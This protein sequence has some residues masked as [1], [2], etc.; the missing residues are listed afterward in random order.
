MKKE[1][2]LTVNETVYNIVLETVG[3]GSSMPP[4][5]S[6]SAAP[7]PRVS[8]PVSAPTPAPAP[9]STSTAAP[10]GRGE[11]V[12]APMPGNVWKVKVKNGDVVKKGDVLIIL[13][14]M[15]MEN[16]IMAMCDGTVSDFSVSEGQSLDSG[17]LIC[18][19]R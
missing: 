6:A 7:L 10:A 12:C 11:T 5:K 14:A 18:I 8:A 13:E 2:K 19:I 9:A 15:K 1:Y 4:R 3:T 16:E 17:A